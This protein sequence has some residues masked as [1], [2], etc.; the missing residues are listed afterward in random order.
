MQT[1]LMRQGIET[2]DYAKEIPKWASL[3]AVV[4]ADAESEEQAAIELLLGGGGGASSSSS[5]P[6]KKEDKDAAAAVETQTRAAKKNIASMIGRSRKAFAILHSALPAEL[7]PLVA[8][9]APGYAFGIWSFLE[10]KY[11]NTE[12]DSVAALWA[13]F[14]TLAQDA[15]ENF[16]SYKARVDS[17]AELLWQ[18]RSCSRR[19]VH[20]RTGTRGAR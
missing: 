16:D 8:E 7:R 20:S 12:Q 11:R 13:D 4:E 9:V 5:T 19:I 1:H 6:M 2:R 14:T 10:K 18:R 3:V 17:V 15:E